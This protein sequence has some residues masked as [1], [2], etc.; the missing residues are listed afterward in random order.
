MMKRGYIVCGY[1]RT[2]STVLCRALRATGKLGYAQEYFNP[3]AIETPDGTTYPA[4]P[5]SQLAEIERRG[6]TPNGIYGVKMFADQFDALKGFDWISS[7][8]QPTFIHL[9]RRDALGQALSHVR[10]NQTGQWS[11]EQKAQHQPLYD[12]AAIKAELARAAGYRARWQMFFARNGLSPLWLVYEDVIADLGGAVRTIAKAVGV[13]LPPDLPPL[14][15]LSPQADAINDAWRERFIAEE[16]NLA[17]LDPLPA[18]IAR[19]ARPHPLA[20]RFLRWVR[21]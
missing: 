1:A 9:E 3:A 18:N 19:S 15:T 21:R 17:R 7:L 11:A 14:V 8:P 10:A 13:E 16:G 2:G 5:T 4:D 6:T 12:A 20:R